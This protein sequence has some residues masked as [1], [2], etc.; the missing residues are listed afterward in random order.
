MQRPETATTRHVSVLHDTSCRCQRSVRPGCAEGVRRGVVRGSASVEEYYA[1]SGQ[2]ALK[3]GNCRAS[4]GP[5][6]GFPISAN[7]SSA[8]QPSG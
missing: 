4:F 2:S 5:W 6:E 7:A 3:A 1:G 8:A